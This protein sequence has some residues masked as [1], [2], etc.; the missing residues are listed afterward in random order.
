MSQATMVSGYAVEPTEARTHERA[1]TGAC[2]ALILVSGLLVG[3]IGVGESGPQ[4]PDG[5]RY[6]NGAAMI[7]DWVKSGRLLEPYQFAT[8]NYLQYPAFSIP[9]HPPAYPAMMGG[10]FLVTGPSYVSARCFVAVWLGIAA[11]AFFMILRHLGMG[12]AAA[13]TGALLLMV[14][15]E[16]VRW[17]RCTMSEI[18]ALGA[19]LLGTWCFLLWLKKDRWYFMLLAFVFAELAFMTKVT[20]VGILPAWGLL[21]LSRPDRRRA[22]SPLLL[23]LAAV[24]VIANGAWVKLVVHQYA[25]HEFADGME[26]RVAPF[27]WDHL[28]FYPGLFPDMLGW[29]TLAVG[30]AGLA[31]VTMRYR[32]TSGRLWLFWFAGYFIFQLAIARNEQRYFTFALPGLIGLAVCLLE[33][34]LPTWLNRRAAPAALAAAVAFG[35]A[36]VINAPRGMTGNDAIAARLATLEKPGNILLAS[37]VDQDLIFRYRGEAGES[38]R[39]FLRSDRLLAIR[40]SR[41]AGVPTEMVAHSPDDVLHMIERGRARYIV[42]CTSYNDAA[43]IRPPDL[44]LADRTVRQFPDRFRKLEEFPLEIEWTP[45]HR[46]TARA[47]LWEFTGELPPGPSDLPVVIPTAGLK[48]EPDGDADDDS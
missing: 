15:P 32:Q 26:T 47:F 24:F 14:T 40:V 23:V 17:T 30:L 3:M 8:E 19:M 39:R 2:L 9:Y 28:S 43:D 48:L 33:E 21:L 46:K 45:G 22:L 5:P 44:E 13:L 6:A 34:H 12:R 35:A 4:W 18:P 7:H 20:S 38:D 1:R 10:W 25:T 27:S 37:W 36:G 16:V 11:G 42:T 29:V 41:Y 31:A